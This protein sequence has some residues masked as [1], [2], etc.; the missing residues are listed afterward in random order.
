MSK[1]GK[2]YDQ[3]VAATDLD[4][5]YAIAKK[6]KADVFYGVFEEA[7]PGPN[8]WENILNI[9]TPQVK[10]AHA[11]KT[12]EELVEEYGLENTD[13]VA[14]MAARR[15]RFAALARRGFA[16]TL[17]AGGQG[18]SAAFGTGVSAQKTLLGA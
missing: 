14:Q 16:S 3:Y 12:A 17:L 13:N 11:P 6:A 2:Y 8:Y 10:A 7:I 5:R 1:K 15:E 18:Q 9:L 4:T